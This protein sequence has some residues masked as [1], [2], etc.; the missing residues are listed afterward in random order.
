[1]VVGV[2]LAD[3]DPDLQDC[4]DLT[5]NCVATA[6]E[7]YENGNYSEAQWHMFVESICPNAGM[8]CAVEI[9]D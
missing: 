1:M 4:A 3:S 6:D 2:N 5:N 9:M 8:Q 7:Q